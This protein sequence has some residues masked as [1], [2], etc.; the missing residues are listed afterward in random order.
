MHVVI[1]VFY[2]LFNC[3]YF[4]LTLL[5]IK[6]T[7]SSPFKHLISNLI[8]NFKFLLTALIALGLDYQNAFFPCSSSVFISVW[9]EHQISWSWEHSVMARY[10][11]F[12]LMRF[13]TRIHVPFP[14]SFFFFFSHSFWD[15]ISLPSHPFNIMYVYLYFPHFTPNFPLKR[16]FSCFYLEL[17]LVLFAWNNIARFLKV[18]IEGFFRNILLTVIFL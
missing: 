7:F 3:Y 13:L 5:N 8:K 11:F 12:S 2:C 6:W 9:L 16:C 18:T 14:V 15:T 4:V 10:K 1:C 17:L